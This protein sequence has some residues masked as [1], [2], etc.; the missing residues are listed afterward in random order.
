MDNRIFK[1]LCQK[2]QLDYGLRNTK[3]IRVDENVD[4]NVASFLMICA[5]NMVQR[6]VA[7]I[8]GHSQETI[9][10][11][12]HEVLEACFSLAGELIPAQSQQ[13]LERV[14]QVLSSNAN[15]WPY[16]RGFIGAMDG[17]HIPVKVQKQKH[18]CFGTDMATQVLI[19]WRSVMCTC[20][21]NM[22][23]LGFQDLPTMQ[24]C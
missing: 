22:H 10:R 1:T 5:H 18:R 17:T 24:E 2:L 20:Y 14:S 3:H 11:N 12:F 4:E 13:D 6:F 21:L 15:Y 16:I 9:N 8:L 19:S 7:I 23:G